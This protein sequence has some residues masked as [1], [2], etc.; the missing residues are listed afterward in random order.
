MLG[1]SPAWQKDIA[2]SKVLPQ[3]SPFGRRLLFKDEKYTV[4]NPSKQMRLHSLCIRFEF[5][6]I[7]FWQEHCLDPFYNH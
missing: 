1:E 7:F 3:N 2:L 4:S 6:L 5:V